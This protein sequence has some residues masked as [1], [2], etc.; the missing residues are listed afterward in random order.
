MREPT[1]QVSSVQTK[2]HM[3]SHTHKKILKGRQ[4]GDEQKGN[5]DACLGE[6]FVTRHK[7]NRKKRTRE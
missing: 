6:Y 2:D 7:D 3:Q 1:S 4:Q 5:E